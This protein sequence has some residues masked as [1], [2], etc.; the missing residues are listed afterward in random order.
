MD[1]LGSGKPSL[2]EAILNYQ[3]ASRL[4]AGPSSHSSEAVAEAFPE[5]TKKKAAHVEGHRE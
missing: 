2:R 3:L 5:S 4:F 1:S